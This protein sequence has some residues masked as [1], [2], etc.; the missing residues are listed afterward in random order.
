M[1]RF[2]SDADLESRLK[3]NVDLTVAMHCDRKYSLSPSSTV[4]DAS[5]MGGS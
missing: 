2:A 4:V 3:L 5:Y 1:N